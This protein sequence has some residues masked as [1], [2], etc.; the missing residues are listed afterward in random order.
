MMVSSGAWRTFMCVFFLSNKMLFFYMLFLLTTTFFP[1]KVHLIAIRQHIYQIISWIKNRMNDDVTDKKYDNC[2]FNAFSF[3]IHV[4]IYFFFFFFFRMQVFFLS[5]LFVNCSICDGF[6]ITRS[7][8]TW[9]CKLNGTFYYCGGIW[10]S[11]GLC[12]LSI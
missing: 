7:E 6:Q 8:L 3:A 4:W 11:Q 12:R 5:L 1:C 9:T 10:L 2:N